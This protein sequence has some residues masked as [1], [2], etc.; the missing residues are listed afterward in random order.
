MPDSSSPAATPWLLMIHQI[1]PK[2]DYFRVKIGRRLQRVGAV[3]VK[4]SVYALPDGDQTL[5][6]FQWIRKEIVDG[7]GDATICRASLVDGLTDDQLRDAPVHADRGRPRDSGAAL[8]VSVGD[9]GRRCN[10][11]GKRARSVLDMGRQRLFLS[12]PK[13]GRSWATRSIYVGA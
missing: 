5:E 6:D 12:L 2:P 13:M 10:A 4:S 11:S 3:A 8:G 9:T 7:G 1:P